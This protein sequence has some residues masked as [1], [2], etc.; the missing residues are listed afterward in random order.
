MNTNQSPTWDQL[1][2]SFGE[3]QQRPLARRFD[4]LLDQLDFGL[5]FKEHNETLERAVVIAGKAL[6][7]L[8]YENDTRNLFELSRTSP[9]HLLRK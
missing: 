2:A 5:I 9:N 1:V 3:Q 4:C 8:R 6:F 7:A